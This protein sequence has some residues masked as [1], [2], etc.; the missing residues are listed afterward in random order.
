[1][2]TDTYL[3]HCYVIP[4]TPPILSLA[5][6]A[7]VAVWKEVE[8]NKAWEF[9]AETAGRDVASFPLQQEETLRIFFAETLGGHLPVIVTGPGQKHPESPGDPAG[10]GALQ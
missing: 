2:K 9:L 3:S 5:D 10:A 8:G 7:F 6:E 4:E 1:M